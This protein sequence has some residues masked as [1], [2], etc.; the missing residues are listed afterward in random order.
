MFG[1]IAISL[2]MMALRWQNELWSLY[3]L[4]FAIGAFGFASLFTPMVA[5]AGRWFSARKGLAIG[6]VTAGGALGQGLVPYSRTC[7]S[8]TPAGATPRSGSGSAIS[9]SCFRC[10]LL[11]RS[12]RFTRHAAARG[13]RLRPESV[14]HPTQDHDPL[15]RLC[16]RVLLHL[17]GGAAGASRPA[18]DRSSAARR[19]PPPACCL[20]AM[21]AGIFGRLFFGSL[22]DR[23]GGLALR[24]S[25]CRADSR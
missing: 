20:S 13:T 1:A 8:R 11:L 22:A 21:I 2:G 5:L 12:P 7:C 25:C 9:S 6:I 14:G 10:V 3:L 15:A 24:I 16:Q 19:R 18:R 4:C 17:H 23:I